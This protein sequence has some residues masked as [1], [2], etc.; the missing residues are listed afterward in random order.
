MRRILYAVALVCMCLT[1]GAQDLGRYKG[2]MEVGMASMK[3]E[4]ANVLTFEWATSHGY[5]FK[6]RFYLGAGAGV[7]LAHG[8]AE[9]AGLG[10][11]GTLFSVP[12]FADTRFYVTP[13]RVKPYIGVRGGYAWGD[14]KGGLFRPSLGLS[15]PINKRVAVNIGFTYQLQNERIEVEMSGLSTGNSWVDAWLGNV[16]TGNQLLES[17]LGGGKKHTVKLNEKVHSVSLNWGFEF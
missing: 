3:M 10:G 5:C 12:V 9:L 17:W 6:D 8:R 16:S 13:T 4:S 2:T 7:Q 11:K 14:G 1:A 15:V